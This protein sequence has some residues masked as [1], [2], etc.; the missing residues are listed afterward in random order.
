[1][2]FNIQQLLDQYI[3]KPN[4]VCLTLIMIDGASDCC[5]LQRYRLVAKLDGHKGPINCVAFNNSGSLLASGGDDET[6]QVWDMRYLQSIQTFADRN[7]RW[8]QITCIKFISFDAIS[9]WMCFGTGRGRFLVYRRLRKSVGG[10]SADIEQTEL[11]GAGIGICRDI[12]YSSIHTWR[13]H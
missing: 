11:T 3:L 13:Q 5:L 8:G 4:D 10:L 1:M 9:D 12:V 6:V 7:R 2:V